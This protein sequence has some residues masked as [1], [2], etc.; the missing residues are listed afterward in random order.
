MGTRARPQRAPV[1]DR[2]HHWLVSGKI[3][4]MLGGAEEVSSFEHNTV[5][6]NTRNYVTANMIGEAQ[7]ALQLQ[8]FQQVGDPHIKMIN[9]HI[10]GVNYLGEMSKEEF[11]T[12][13]PADA[14]NDDGVAP[15]G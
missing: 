10:Q 6:T 13:P 4:F 3:M 7:Q 11:Y 9:V 12:P 5:V 8:L 2:R 15:E 14:S 1:K